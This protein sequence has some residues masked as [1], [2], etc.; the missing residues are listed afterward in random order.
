VTDYEKI[1]R[2]FIAAWPRLSVDEIVSYFAEGGVYADATGGR[3]CELAE[4][5]S[6][7]LE[8]LDQDRLGCA[9]HVER[10]RG[11][12]GAIGS[13]HRGGGKKVDLPCCGVFAMSNGKIKV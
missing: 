8:E 4:L 12:R 2:E 9:Q 6:G 13:R 11:D 3:S 10:Q 1:I 5:H 7:V